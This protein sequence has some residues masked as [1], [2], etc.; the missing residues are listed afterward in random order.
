MFKIDTGSDV[1]ILNRNLVGDFKS[2]IFVGNCCLKYPTG[3][4]VPV[5][6]K[7]EVTVSLGKC[8][9]MEIPM[10]VAEIS[11][12]CILGVD[13]LERSNLLGIFDPIFGN[14]DSEMFSCSR[15][16]PVK[17]PIFLEKLF[18]LNSENLDSTQ[19]NV[20]AQFLWEFQDVFFDNITPGNCKILEHTI[21]VNN[22][23]PIKQAPRRVPIHLRKEVN[24]IL[25]DMKRQGIIEE[26]NSP[27]VSPAVLV[28]KKDGSIRFCVDYRKLNAVTVKDS[29]PLPRIEDILDQLA[30]NSWFST[31]DLKSG[32]WQVG[33]HPDDKEK[34]AFSVGNGLWQFTVMP[35]GLCNAPAT[36]ERLMEKVLREVLFKIC[37]VY[38]D[39]VIVFSKTFEE[40]IKNLGK[41]FLRFRSANLKINPKKCSLFG[42]KVKYLGHVSEEGISTDPEKISAVKDWPIPQ[43]KKQIRSFLGFCSYYRKFVEGFSLV[44]KPLFN[45]TGDQ[46]KFRWTQECQEA[47]DILKEKLVSSSI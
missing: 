9:G 23:N 4:E 21:S 20:F 5:L 46:V 40:M 38:L 19:K 44:A 24:G 36:F 37:Y 2:K 33:L 32:Y 10:L 15:I 25:E 43:N 1:S 29:Y 26:S 17:V 6:F 28:K 35:F 8:L 30:G 47:F 45:L 11:D 16:T 7:T 41:V 27:W 18:T 31:L 39:D 34:T 3:E 13:F 14:R 12:E 22:S 42:R